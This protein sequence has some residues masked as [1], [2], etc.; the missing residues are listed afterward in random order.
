MAHEETIQLCWVLMADDA[1]MGS[2]LAEARNV[3]DEVVG[4]V[5]GDAALAEKAAQSGF[6]R[7]LNIVVPDEYVRED[8]ATT[9]S[10]LAARDCPQLVLSNGSAATRMLLGAVAEVLDAKILADV[11]SLRSTSQGAVAR[12]E[13]A[14]GIA[15]KEY[16]VAAP[17]AGVFV[18]ADAEAPGGQAIVET[19]QAASATSRL[20]EVMPAEQTG[21]A[22][23][24]KVVGVGMGVKEGQLDAVRA[25]AEKI[26]AELACTLPVC[27]DRHWLAPSRVLG[28]SHSQC[29]PELYIALG[30]S[31]SPN[32]LS[33]VRDAKIVV[34]VNRDADAPIFKRADY[35]IAA[36]IED[37]LPALEKA[38]S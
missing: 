15:C 14:G 21:L 27:D 31:G 30:I 33:G 6:D 32:H 16:L 17:L 11:V 23:A 9:V 19:C 26:G 22:S 20:I 12:C 37:A 10:E 1:R 24:S 18:G 29:S 35:G 3:S 28:S 34:A 13:V 25:F 5:V 4:V 7:V 8:A 2:L 36:Q 38:F